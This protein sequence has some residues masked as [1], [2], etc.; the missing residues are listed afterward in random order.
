LARGPELLGVAAGE[1]GQRPV[2]QVLVAV[3]QQ[4]L[5]GAVGHRQG[6]RV[7]RRRRPVEV[8]QRELVETGVLAVGA[9]VARRDDA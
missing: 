1:V 5:R 9:L 8:G 4:R 2:D 7:Q 3:V 6:T